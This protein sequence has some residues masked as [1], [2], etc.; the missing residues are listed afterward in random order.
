M[1]KIKTIFSFFTLTILIFLYNNSTNFK[2]SSDKENKNSTQK[3][4]SQ[5][6]NKLNKIG[7]LSITSAKTEGPV[8]N[9]FIYPNDSCEAFNPGKQMGDRP[10]MAARA[11]ID[12]TNKIQF[13]SGYFNMYRMEGTNFNNL[14]RIC[15][16]NGSAAV[17]ISPDD[18]NYNNHR[19]LEW[20]QAFY[21]KD[22]RNVSAI[23]SVDWNGFL[24]SDDPSCNQDI[25]VNP[26]ANQICWWN[27]IT[28][29]RSFDSGRSFIPA[30]NN[31][32]VNRP[33]A[34]PEGDP[35]LNPNNN[36]RYGYFHVTNILKDPK[37]GH[38]FFFTLT[39]GKASEKGDNSKLQSGLC[40]MRAWSTDDL[41]N[42]N[43]W[44][45]WSGEDS[46]TYPRNEEPCKKIEVP[47]GL[48]GARFLGYST[49]FNKY[50]LFSGGADKNGFY[51]ALSDRLDQW[52]KK[53]Y[54]IPFFKGKTLYYS[55]LIDH[56][57]QNLT[58]L[59]NEPT[60]I[61]K[62]RRN[63]DIVGQNPYVYFVEKTEN[64]YPVLKR[65]KLNFSK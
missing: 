9:V 25:K 18:H 19:S 61:E 65:V 27:K 17:L 47:T 26:N 51:F 46:V 1:T 21:T 39:S 22:G 11:I 31:E 28:A 14:K 36:G 58:Q 55:T 35:K 2:I 8:E 52:P 42:P 40:L 23:A 37:T 20:L 30:T 16:T 13:Y 34:I 45:S 43:S 63:F 12:S 10:D 38:Y 6:S 53:S 3:I 60:A 7:K 29:F 56:N 62:E 24:H 41:S 4:N 5:N 57:Y 59:L 64:S 48:G 49:Y 50:I 33:I 44:A 54:N 32:Y 15:G